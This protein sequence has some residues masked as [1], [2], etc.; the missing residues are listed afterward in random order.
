M[1]HQLWN[2]PVHKWLLRTVYFP[3][4][5]RKVGRFSAM[6]AVFLVSAV[7][8]ELVLGVPLGMLRGWAFAGIMLQV[9]RLVTLLRCVSGHKDVML[10]KLD[11]QGLNSS[12]LYSSSLYSTVI[13]GVESGD[14]WPL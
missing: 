4:L 10:V 8:H 11:V 3:L 7:F 1:P 5:R 2:M 12:S 6:L 9:C 13:V 14:L